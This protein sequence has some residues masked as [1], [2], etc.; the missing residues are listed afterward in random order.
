MT[1]THYIFIG[2]AILIIIAVIGYNK[3]WFS[4]TKDTGSNQHPDV[5]KYKQ[6]VADIS[7]KSSNELVDFIVKEMG[8]DK[9][10]V[11]GKANDYLVKFATGHCQSKFPH[12]SG[13][14]M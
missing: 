6:C 4:S 2:I 12:H 9:E 13:A 1:K 10:S 14:E 7:K 11:Q 8:I 3:G 5:E